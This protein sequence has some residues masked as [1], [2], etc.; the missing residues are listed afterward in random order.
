MPE[1]V[2]E[3]A[4]QSFKNKKPQRTVSLTAVVSHALLGSIRLERAE[5]LRA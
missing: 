1:C 5:A 3:H 2:A 4:T